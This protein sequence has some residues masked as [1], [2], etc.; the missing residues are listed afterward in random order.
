MRDRMSWGRVGCWLVALVLC[1]GSFASAATRVGDDII[2]NVDPVPSGLSSETHHGYFEYRVRLT[3]TSGSQERRVQVRLPDGQGYSGGS[4]NVSEIE[5]EVTVAPG[6]ETVVSLLQPPLPITHDRSVR[7]TAGGQSKSISMDGVDHVTSYRHGSVSSVVL[8]SKAVD[9]NFRPRAEA[10]SAGIQVSVVRSEVEIHNWSTNWLAYTCY[11]GLVLT[12]DDMR[13]IPAQAKQAIKRYVM[14]GGS[15]TVLG[16]W[17]P[18]QDWYA[19]S[20][21]E[22]KTEAYYVGFGEAVVIGEKDP[23]VIRSGTLNALSRT[24]FRSH[25]TWME[26]RDDVSSA[27]RR[28]AVVEDLGVPTGGLLLLMI[29]FAVVIGPVNLWY[30]GRIKKRM[31]LMWTVPAISLVFCLAVWV[32]ATAAEGWRGRER[33]EG[34]TLLDERAAVAITHGMTAFYSPLTPGGGLRFSA[35]TEVTPQI[36][37]YQDDR[38]RTVD[39]TKQQHLKTGWIVARVPAHFRV[40]KCDP[41]Q[42]GRINPTINTDGDITAVNGLGAACEVLYLADENGDIH[43]ARDTRAGEAFDLSDSGG[44]ASGGADALRDLYRK[45]TPVEMLAEAERRY[46]QLLQPNS[47][48][49]VLDDNPFIESGMGKEDSRKARAIVYGLVEIKRQ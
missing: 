48:I 38:R 21:D 15:L 12:D 24:W 1:A 43:V 33:T 41:T 31:W 9:G 47:Y 35:D 42:R 39:W 8:V 49:A 45:D 28:F 10:H 14:A 11:E 20:N 46:E 25:S 18:E 19:Q 36:D 26:E 7:V 2:V 3:N 13:A 22:H 37:F 29:A 6:T 44:R 40:R 23:N 16:R 27:N 30:L 5:R 17:Q 32:Y 4:A 34:L